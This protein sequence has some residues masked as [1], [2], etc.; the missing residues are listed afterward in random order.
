MHRLTTILPHPG[1]TQP[2]KETRSIV[3]GWYFYGPQEVEGPHLLALPDPWEVGHSL[4]IY[5]PPQKLGGGELQFQ[6]SMCW[7]WG[8]SSLILGQD[9]TSGP[10]ADD[11]EL[12]TPSCSLTPSP[13]ILC[14]HFLGPPKTYT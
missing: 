1:S 7:F 14:N 6:F 9:G 2:S 4:C 3:R 8:L 10:P 11:W 12:Q 13:C 5:F